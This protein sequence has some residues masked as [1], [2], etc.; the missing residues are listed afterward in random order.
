MKE[1]DIIAKQKQSKNEFRKKNSQDGRG[2]PTYIYAR[3]GDD[4]LYLGLTHAEI[5]KG[6]RN[7]RLDKNP[8]PKDSRTA[9]VRPKAEKNN[10]ASFGKKLQ[11]WSFSDSDK[12]KIKK[13]KK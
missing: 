6:V 13:Y 9:Y 7:I 11:G 2:H 5:T 8:N 12:E 3:Q 1:G 10:K 4:Y